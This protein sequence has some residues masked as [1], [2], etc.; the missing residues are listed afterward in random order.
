MKPSLLILAAGMGSRY[1]GLKQIDPVGPNGEAIM[2]YSIHDALRAGFG[3][4]IFV[5]RP[6]FEEALKERIGSKLDG[7]AD[8]RYVYQE[9]ELGLDGYELP[10]ERDKP[11]GTAHAILAGKDAVDEPFAV[12]NADDYYGIDSFAIMADFLQGSQVSA[13]QYAMVGYPLRNTLSD[14]GTVSR[15]VCRCDENSFLQEITERTAIEKVGAGACYQDEEG[16]TRKLSGDELVSMNLWGFHPQFLTHLETCFHDFL[17]EQGHLPKSEYYI[18][19]PISSLMEKQLATVQ[20]LPTKDRWFG[21]TYKQDKPI[22]QQ[23]IAQLIE[24][25]AYRSD[26]WG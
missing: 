10:P 11:W 20:V 5:I 22:V 2:D 25:G 13:S 17:R 7:R 3:K 1:G 23:G 6:M 19:Y 24:A 18:A 16:V 8:V 21:V 14:Y 26:L 15:G 9:L 4:F 12:I